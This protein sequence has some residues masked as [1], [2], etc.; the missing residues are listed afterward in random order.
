M[1]RYL[2]ILV[3]LCIAF[4]SRAQNIQEPAARQLVATHVTEI[5]LPG[6]DLANFIVSSAYYDKPD[7]IQRVYLQQSY[8]S[9][10]V[11][12]KMIVLAFRNDK[13]ISRAGAFINAMDSVAENKS[14]TPFL[15]STDAIHT[16]FTEAKIPVPVSMTPL[17]IMEN[18]RKINYGRSAS[19]SE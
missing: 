10:P 11:Y 2:L 13:L 19:V 8:K 12:N 6:N 18:G 7:D 9:L 17:E 14:A 4:Y 15:A 1:K 16:A 5:G 3:T